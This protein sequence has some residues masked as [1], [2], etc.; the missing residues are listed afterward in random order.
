MEEV[1]EKEKQSFFKL[2]LVVLGMVLGLS[3]LIGIL[4]NFKGRFPYL[5]TMLVI[6]LVVLACGFILVTYLSQLVYLLT[7]DYLVFS[8]RIGRKDYEI[9][10]VALDELYFIGGGPDDLE[11]KKPLY[12]FG[13][14]G[15]DKCL[16]KYRR[17]GKTFT[18]LFS[19]SEEFL[20]ALNK[21]A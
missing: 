12:D 9:L 4:D 1:L 15:G 19:P 7:E 5:T 13:L 8:R 10:R 17:E 21:E 11:G 18:F 20:R 3:F 2:V 16:G 14:D 6:G